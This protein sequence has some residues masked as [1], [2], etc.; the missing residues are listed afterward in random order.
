MN[1]RDFLSI[2]ALG[3]RE[4]ADLL[5]LAARM[6]RRGP[7]QV[8]AGKTLGLLFFERS[9]RTRVSFH[10]AMEQL[11]GHCL[12][13]FADRDIYDLEAQDR[14]VMV[15][16]AEEHVQDAARTL[17]RYVDALG[18]RHLP[19]ATSWAEARAEALVRAY[20]EYASVP[21]INLET[22]LEH[23][24]QAIADMLTIRERLIDVRGR[25][26]TLAWGYDPEPKSLG[27]SHSVLLSAAALGLNV[28]LA[29]P[30]GF[31]LDPQIVE[32]ARTRAT[33]SG[34]SVRVVN[35]L[36]EGVR[37]AHV[38]Y[39]RSW[40]SLKFYADP[41]RESIVKRS[42]EGWRI[43]G[44][45]LASTKNAIFMHPL[46]VRRNVVATD[47]V[48]DGPQSVIYDQ[49]ENRLHAGKALLVHLLGG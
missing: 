2:Q 48:L 42:L 8:L 5:D 15:G 9:L 45:L 47:D 6:K 4:L 10:V 30:L 13:L 33:E 17:S 18:I 28:T 20:A 29:H 38:L 26:L 40:R 36:A 23:P 49:A 37:E 39:A 31:E 12:S 34:G 14:A 21:V 44:E 1:K 43:D 35:D 27:V 11:G 22:A 46:P 41:E 19:P 24:C 32:A 7:G 25:N 3:S 16:S